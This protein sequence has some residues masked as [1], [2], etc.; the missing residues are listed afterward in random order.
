MWGGEDVV[1]DDDGVEWARNGECSGIDHHHAFSIYSPGA[2]DFDLEK[3]CRKLK[4]SECYPDIALS[5]IT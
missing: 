2:L 3:K 1:D 4:F 5:L